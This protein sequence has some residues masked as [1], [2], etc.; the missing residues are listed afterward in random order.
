MK[1]SIWVALGAV[2]TLAVAGP[3]G[4]T[5]FAC[6]AGCPVTGGGFSFNA[7]YTVPTNGQAY[8]WDL[9]TD[10]PGVTITLTAPNEVFDADIVSNGN[11]TFHNDSF[12]L[13]T[14]FT[15]N[16]IQGPSHTTIYTQ[17]L[18]SN[19][20]HCSSASP[21]GEICG[22]SFNVWGN[23]S[24]LLLNTQSTVTIF[25]SQTPAPEPATWALMLTGFFGLGSMLRRRRAELAA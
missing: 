4:A 25:F 15:W 8:R 10:T 24:H 20:N 23:G 6:A 12:L 13:P 14:T 18:R 3:A 9:W 17:G 19:F 21:T 1:R 7:D 2:A 11:G 5:I 16:E 22:A